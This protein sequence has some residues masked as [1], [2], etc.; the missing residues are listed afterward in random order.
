MFDLSESSF[1]RLFFDKNVSFNFLETDD[2]KEQIT[3]QVKISRA[4]LLQEKLTKFMEEMNSNM[5]VLGMSSVELEY[6]GE[7]FFPLIV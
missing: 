1:K 3:E 2:E 4:L 5:K 7:S 6:M